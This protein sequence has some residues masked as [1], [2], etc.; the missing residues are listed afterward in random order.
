MKVQ[1]MSRNARLTLGLALVGLLVLANVP[2]ARA[3]EGQGKYITEATVRLI[4][5][6]DAA[7]KDGYSLADNSFSTGGGWLKQSQ[8]D[9]IPLFTVQLQEGKEYRFLAAG[10]ADA[11]DV[12]IEILDADN[13]VVAQDVDTAANAHVNFS[14]KA[15]G[16]YL[17]RIRLY[18]SDKNLPCMCLAIVMSK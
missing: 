13:K 15:T 4:K 17:V 11:K 2:A 18:D 16:R 12:D 6:V 5:L 8:K 14:P 10:D 9:W 3:Q 7:N 1:R